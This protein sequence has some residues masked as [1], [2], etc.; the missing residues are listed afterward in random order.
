MTVGK[1]TLSDIIKLENY[2]KVVIDN[3]VIT[4]DN[5]NYLINVGYIRVSTDRQAE[6]GYGLDI[7]EKDVVSYCKRNDFDNLLLFVD[8]GYTGTNMDRPALQS[9][10]AMITNFNE[11]SSNIRINAMVIPR[12]DRLGRTLLGTLQFIQDYIVAESDSKNSLV[13]RNREDINF[14]SVSENYCRIERSNPQGK[15]LLMLFASLAEFDRDLIVDKLKKGKL[16]RISSGKWMGG[17]IPPYGYIYDKDLGMLVTVPEEAE[18]VKEVFRLYLEEKMS[19]QKI[20]N[21]LGL[22]GERIVSNILHRKT[23]IG[24]MIYNGIEYEGEHVPIISAETWQEAQEELSRRS[25]VRGDTDYLL[26]GL[27]YCGECGAKMRYQKWDKHTGEC[28]LV[29]YSHQKSKSYLV[30][31]ENCENELYWQSDIE[32]AVAEELFALRYIGEKENTK[33]ETFIDPIKS[34]TEQL[35]KEKSRL[36]KLYDLVD[37]DIDTVLHEKI[38]TSKKKINDLQS[39]IE[40]ETQQNKIRKKIENAKKIVRTLKDTWPYMTAKEKQS[41][42][43]ELIERVVIYKNGTVDV[44]LKLKSYLAKKESKSQKTLEK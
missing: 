18:K 23:Y 32:N 29:C 25:T 15:F 33:K 24:S 7:Q 2:M 41:V 40:S 39:M 31:D 11:G 1:H 6:M 22:K 3:G 37:D 9:I 44:H 12:I 16:A 28:K 8:D 35:Q 43:R 20:A 38:N 30:K 19:P 21:K 14:I 10:I 13:N 36:S 42:A 27:I 34:L 4:D 5:G 26:S 17:G